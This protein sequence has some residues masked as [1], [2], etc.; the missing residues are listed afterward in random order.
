MAS[1][2]LLVPQVFSDNGIPLGGAG[3][4]NLAAMLVLEQPDHIG[5]LRLKDRGKG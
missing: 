2:V 4:T 3:A 1:E 5:R